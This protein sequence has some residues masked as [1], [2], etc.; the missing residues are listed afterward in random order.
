MQNEDNDAVGLTPTKKAD[1]V[2]CKENRLQLN[3]FIK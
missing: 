3:I 2:S 1:E